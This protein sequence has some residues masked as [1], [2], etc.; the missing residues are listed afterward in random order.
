MTNR[1]SFP[2]GVILSADGSVPV[3]H[4]DSE[5]EFHEGG[6]RL[7]RGRFTLTDADDVAAG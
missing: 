2:V 3:V 7:R 4:V 6:R 1:N 5:L